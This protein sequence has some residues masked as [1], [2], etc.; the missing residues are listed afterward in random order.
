MAAGRKNLLIAALL[1]LLL[2]A[3]CSG[4]ASG[5]AVTRAA[6]DTLDAGGARYALDAR[7]RA[8]GDTTRLRG[9][10]AFDTTSGKGSLDLT[11]ASP[12]RSATFDGVLDGDVLWLGAANESLDLPNGK[13]WLKFDRRWQLGQGAADLAALAGRTPGDVLSLLRRTS[14]ATRVGSE[15]VGGVATTHY[16]AP[17]DADAPDESGEIVQE[18]DPRYRPLDVWVDDAGRVRK[19]ALDYSVAFG[20]PGAQRAR[21]TLAMR[22]PRFGVPVTI[23]RPPASDTLDANRFGGN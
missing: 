14:S 3:G 13:H 11:L 1:A 4:S 2:P 22:F 6:E 12:G 9:G 10:G 8:A 5:T 20:E 17:L 21:I 7:V 19:V 16:R 15:R 18:M 23:R